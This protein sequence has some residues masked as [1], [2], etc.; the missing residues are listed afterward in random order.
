[1]F[2]ISGDAANWRK[3]IVR[4]LGCRAL[5][6]ADAWRAEGLSGWLRCAVR[7]GDELLAQNALVEIMA[8][9]E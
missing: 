1:M 5:A 2:N 8:G 3:S 6:G 9:V 7:F 4:G